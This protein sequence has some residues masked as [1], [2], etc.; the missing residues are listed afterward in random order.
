VK[1]QRS[2]LIVDKSFQYSQIIPV[3]MIAVLAA[4]S[5]LIAIFFLLGSEFTDR[6]Q[7]FIW[8]VAAIVGFFRC[9][10]D[11]IMAQEPVIGLPARSID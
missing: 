4:N 7:L 9:C 3:V 1:N 8:L 5:V 2:T 10:S 6:L 11:F